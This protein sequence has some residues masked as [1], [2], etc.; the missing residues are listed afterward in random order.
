VGTTTRDG[1]LPPTRAYLAVA[2]SLF[3]LFAVLIPVMVLYHTVAGPYEP[4]L[5][6]AG[7]DLTLEFWPTRAKERHSY[8]ISWEGKNIGLSAAPPQ[9]VKVRLVESDG[10]KGLARRVA[11]LDLDADSDRRGE[12]P[13]QIRRWVEGCGVDSSD[14]QAAH[15]VEAIERVAHGIFSRPGD[16]PASISLTELGVKTGSGGSHRSSERLSRFDLAPLGLC[17][18]IWAA[19][20]WCLLKRRGRTG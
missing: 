4:R 10:G 9:I 18:V 1:F 17:A 19:G 13:S 8:M 3:V 20:M 15:E 14:G 7:G 12:M 6:E 11:S 16:Q 5:V 2:W